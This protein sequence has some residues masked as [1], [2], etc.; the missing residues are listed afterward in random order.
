M[1]LIHTSDLHIG[2]PLTTVL[3]ERGARTRR[4][5]LRQ[6]LS[7]LSE[8]A[9]RLG[10]EGIIIAGD[11]FDSNTPSVL[12]T[13]LFLSTVRAYPGI[14]YFYLSGNHDGECRLLSQSAPDNIY[15]FK[16]EFTEFRIGEVS[17][18]GKARL[19]RAPFAGLKLDTKRVNIV[20]MH[21]AED[22]SGED[23][24]SLKDAAHLGIDY[25]ALGHYHSYSEKKIDGRG[26]RVYCG[27]PEGRGFDEAHP[28]GY[29]L[30]DTARGVRH[31]FV[32]FAKRQIMSIVVDISDANSSYDVEK[33]ISNSISNIDEE[34]LVRV[35][36]TGKARPELIYDTA[37]LTEVFA[38]RF[39]HLEIKDS[40]LPSH[41]PDASLDDRSLR[42]EF[43]RILKDSELDATVGARVREL[44]LRA[45]RGE[46][47]R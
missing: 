19:G 7:R 33:L 41:E 47:L 8:E 20:V 17:I 11:L 22:S 38:P 10:C 21:G 16:D 2:S 32:P 5:E 24:F 30:I 13:E 3:D 12:D 46:K 40:A 35:T 18:V 1:R 23:S 28:C 4:S 14:A 26:V 44:G 42:G 29:V 39:F 27:T 43:L 15:I 45:L 9:V 34:S 37:Y 6:T 31:N 36:L 25:L